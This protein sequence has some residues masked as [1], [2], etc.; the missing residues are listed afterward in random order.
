MGGDPLLGGGTHCGWVGTYYGVIPIIGWW[1]PLWVGWYLLWGDTHY[2]VV[3]P[4][5]GGLVPIMG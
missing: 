3:V 2:W 4:I 5:V 1:Y